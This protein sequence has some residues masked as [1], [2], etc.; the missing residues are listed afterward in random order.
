MPG[1][2]RALEVL[3]DGLFDYAGM[4][5][6][7][8]LSFD[9]AIIASASFSHE[10][11]RPSLVGAD[12]VLGVEHLSRLRIELLQ[13]IGFDSQRAFLVC[14]L[15][16]TLAAAE[17]PSRADELKSLEL[18]NRTEANSSIRR[19]I[20]SYELK[21]SQNL[22]TDHHSAVQRVSEIQS[23]L[24][25][26]RLMIFLEP[27][28]S[29]AAWESVLENICGVI[30]VVNDSSEGPRIGLKARASGPTAATPAKFAAIISEVA[31]AQ[32][33]FKATAGLHH[34]I[35]ERARYHNELGFLNMATALYL[36]RHLGSAFSNQDLLGC[37]TCE[38]S[39]AYRFEDELQWNE[40]RLSVRDLELLKEN[41]HF[42]IGS[43]SLHEPDQD[44]L[45]LFG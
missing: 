18:F 27:D 32:L 19:H 3:V 20:V 38:Q 5:P 42:S 31:T 34:P 39:S 30:K 2:K 35:V 7:S 43:C 23:R 37:L 45:R 41:F 8:S 16:S 15:G 22:Q 25:K 14:V 11:K 28:L 17:E 29:V 24:E 36:K 1:S 6:P 44:L 33:H 10:L 9:D 21:L 26:E 40:Q 13:Q 12:L 4:F